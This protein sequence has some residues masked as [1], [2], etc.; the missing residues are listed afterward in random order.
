MPSYESTT[1]RMPADQPG[2]CAL[3]QDTLPFYIEGDLSPES[4]AFIDAHLETCDRCGSFLAG[5]QSIRGH[6]RREPM[7]RS[8]VI[9][10]DWRAREIITRAAPSCS[11]LS[12]ICLS[13]TCYV[14]AA[15]FRSKASS[16]APATIF[17]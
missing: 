14:R 2:L 12:R 17:I 9:D 3:I 8:A 5:A 6:F 13:L 4:R 1:R 10:N 16:R 15:V 11:I 7:A